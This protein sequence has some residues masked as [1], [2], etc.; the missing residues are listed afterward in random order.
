M[1]TNQKLTLNNLKV[2]SFVTSLGKKNSETVKG[3]S[4]YTIVVPVVATI[5]LYTV[6]G[7]NM[8]DPH[9][10]MCCSNLNPDGCK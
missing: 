2:E 10:S 9:D 4:G 6:L 7:N 8:K 1:K 5:I 3:G